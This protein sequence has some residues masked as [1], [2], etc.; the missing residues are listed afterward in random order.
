MTKGTNGVWETNVLLTPE[1]V[2]EDREILL[3]IL[4]QLPDGVSLTGGT[5]VLRNGRI[6]TFRMLGTAVVV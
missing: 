3:D 5:F 2:D 4:N 1:M 6:W